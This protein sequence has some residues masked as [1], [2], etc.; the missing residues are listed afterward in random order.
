MGQP[1]IRVNSDPPPSPCFHLISSRGW[2]PFRTLTPRFKEH[3]VKAV[4]FKKLLVE[5]VI[6][7]VGPN[8]DCL[9][10]VFLYVT[11]SG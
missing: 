11:W 4:H 10:L 3:K 8:P 1:F 5:A 7:V 6:Y 2:I 9:N